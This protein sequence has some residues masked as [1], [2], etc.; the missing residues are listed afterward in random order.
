MLGCGY[1]DGK[2]IM[3]ATAFIFEVEFRESEVHAHENVLLLQCPK[4]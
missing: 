2:K 4:L 1:D 3:M